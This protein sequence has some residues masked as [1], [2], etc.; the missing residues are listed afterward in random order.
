MKRPNDYADS[1]FA[2]IKQLQDVG[3]QIDRTNRMLSSYEDRGYL[4]LDDIADCEL[5]IYRCLIAIKKAAN[6]IS[7]LSIPMAP[8]DGLTR[9]QADSWIDDLKR[10]IESHGEK[11]NRFLSRPD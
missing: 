3:S 11:C 6:C 5:E 10:M 1:F 7:D 4:Y 9:E 8:F 2:E